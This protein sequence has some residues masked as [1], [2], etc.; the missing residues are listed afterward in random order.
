[1]ETK[2]INRREFVGAGLAAAAGLL[3]APRTGFSDQAS[4]KKPA[5]LKVGLYSITY[6]GVW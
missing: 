1:M 2:S 3:A 6:L 4:P 5:G